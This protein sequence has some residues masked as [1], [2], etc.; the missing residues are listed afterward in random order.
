MVKKQ[1]D[2]KGSNT[3]G[4]NNNNNNNNAGGGGVSAGGG[5]GVKPM[6]LNAVPN[7]DIMQRMNFLWQASVYLGGLG[8]GRGEKGKDV[9]VEGETPKIGGRKRRRRRKV[10]ADV[11]DL[12]RIYVRTMKTVGQKAT[13][14]MSSGVH[15]HWLVYTCL[16]C[17]M[18]RRIPAPHFRDTNDHTG[19]EGMDIDQTLPEP[20]DQQQQ[21]Q[22]SQEGSREENKT[23]VDKMA[24]HLVEETKGTG[25][26]TPFEG[27]KDTVVQEAKPV[28]K[29]K[30]KKKAKEARVPPLFARRDAGHVVYR[31]GEV[32]DMEGVY[33]V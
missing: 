14:K 21:Q 9:M 2:N 16:E 19:D 6:N 11:R 3:G 5:G 30:S 20:N 7:R 10:E 12:A 23:D 18:Q 32:I 29:A 31:G 13:V 15:E 26:N 22:Q 33:C 17:G 28:R 4:S 24:S 8:G 27:E 1:K 25:V